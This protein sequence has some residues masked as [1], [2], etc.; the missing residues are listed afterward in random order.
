MNTPGSNLRTLISSIGLSVAVATAV[1]VPAGYVLVAHS[2]VESR[3]SFEA[4]IK[5][6]RLAKHI[7]SN[8]GLWQ[9]QGVRLAEL[10]EVPEANET[11][12]R[13]RVFD[14]SGRLVME[15]GETPAFPSRGDRKSTRLNSSHV[16]TSRMPSSA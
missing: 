16:T 11:A 12:N 1:L 14:A 10:I 8:A 5:A 15:M 4:Q 2:E 6:N 3:L 7:Y 9:Y 13:Q